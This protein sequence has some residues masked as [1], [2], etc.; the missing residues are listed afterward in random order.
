MSRF[1]P[2][3]DDDGVT[4]TVERTEFGAR[5]IS[6]NHDPRPPRKVGL[7]RYER[8]EPAYR[9]GDTLP[10]AQVGWRDDDP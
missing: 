3:V 1:A 8:R 4:Y 5:V 7:T 9:V 10:N 6:V 2:W